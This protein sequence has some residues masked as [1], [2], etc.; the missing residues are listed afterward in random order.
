VV[1]RKNKS[2]RLQIRIP[3]YDPRS[4]PYFGRDSHVR[5]VYLPLKSG[6]ATHIWIMGP[7][8]FGKTIEMKGLAEA[9]WQYY[10]S[11]GQK[12]LII[13]FERK[14]DTTKY[15]KLRDFYYSEVERL[16][17]QEARERY[18]FLSKYIYHAEHGGLRHLLGMP[19]DFAMGLPNYTFKQVYINNQ[20]KDILSWHV[21]KPKAFPNRRIVFRPTRPLEAIMLDNGPFTEV[22]E[23]KISYSQIDFRTLAKRTHIIS[24]TRYARFIEKFWDIERIRDPD[25]VIQ[26]MKAEYQRM[27]KSVEPPDATL[28]SVISIMEMLKKDR[29]FTKGKEHDFTSLITADRINIID[30]SQNSDLT[31]MEE[32][33][34]FKLLV[35]Y[36]TSKYVMRLKIPTFIFVDEIQD[37][38]GTSN[39]ATSDNPAWLAVEDIYRKGRSMEI[40][41]VAS[42]Q[43][44]YRLPLNLIIG[45]THVVVAGRLAGPRDKKILQDLVPDAHKV[46][47]QEE[48]DTL[49]EAVLAM[50]NEKYRGW[51]CVNK[52]FTVRMYFRPAQ[53]F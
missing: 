29:L 33:I 23:G 4:G 24:G 20:G 6:E 34:I 50:Q 12:V 47:A 43:Y 46:K 11:K 16:G 14:F 49:E 40:A 37:L 25:K 10:H 17:K 9:L 31:P 21:L 27:G 52:S 7:S 13:I 8:G 32:K 3:H 48:Y 22:R 18:D 42:T 39:Q 35:D 44:M 2:Q 5:Q 28:A 36:V 45:A 1:S 15:K 41:L 26:A 38:I 30:F 53:S 51:F 19:G